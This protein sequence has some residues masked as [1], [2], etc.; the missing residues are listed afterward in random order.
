M[1]KFND[2]ENNE[3][4]D[5]YYKIENIQNIDF[6]KDQE[7]DNNIPDRLGSTNDML[8]NGNIT[9]INFNELNGLEEYNK[10]EKR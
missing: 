9:L 3:E 1:G 6:E 4:L 5:I 8:L 2:I 7:T 10:I